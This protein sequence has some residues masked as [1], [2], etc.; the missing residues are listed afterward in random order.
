M[1]TKQKQPKTK[2]AGKARKAQKTAA[3][4]RAPKAPRTRERDPRLPA[5]GTIL[6]RTYKGKEHRVKVL[7]DGFEYGGETFRSLT[8]AAKRA[9][10]YPS[11]SGTAWW[12]VAER[13]PATPKPRKSK[14]KPAAPSD[15]TMEHAPAAESATA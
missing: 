8:A 14:E 13:A 11:I 10:G 15:A 12:N 5:P 1:S 2:T 7:E 9:T 6:T 4:T 3:P